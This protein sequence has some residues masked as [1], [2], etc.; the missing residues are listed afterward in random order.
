MES[1]HMTFE[2]E[3][4]RSRPELRRLRQENAHLKRS[5]EILRKKVL[6]LEDENH[7]LVEK[8]RLLEKK[9]EILL[10]TVSLQG[11]QIES[12]NL[13]VEE[14]RGMVFRKKKTKDDED[15]A[16]QGDAQLNSPQT[17][18]RKSANRSKGSYGR[19]APEEDEVT[20][21]INHPL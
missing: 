14:L 20:H 15:S 16:G 10:E 7:K 5:N 3:V 1:A 12:L 4:L 13:M 6:L 18:K 21:T 17:S 11:K 19:A 8:N 9:Q 2:E